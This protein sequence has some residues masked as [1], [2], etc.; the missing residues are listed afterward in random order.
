[1]GK[2]VGA[3]VWPCGVGV[4]TSHAGAAIELSVQSE[5]F[6]WLG[7]LPCPRQ[8]AGYPQASEQG[9]VGACVGCKI[10]FVLK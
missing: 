8:P 6:N 10:L 2:A 9:E 1:M 3:G 4:R 7:R 5:T